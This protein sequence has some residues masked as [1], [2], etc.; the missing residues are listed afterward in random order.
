MIRLKIALALLRV[1]RVIKK[2]DKMDAKKPWYAS[3]AVWG[4]IISV[5]A[6]LLV[7]T[8][9]AVDVETQAVVAENMAIICLGVVNVVGGIMAIIGRLKA[10]KEIQ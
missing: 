1:A 10:K 9:I 4:G 7:F 2:G 5:I 3:T 8:G 6:P